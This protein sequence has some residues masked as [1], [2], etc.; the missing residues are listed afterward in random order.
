MWGSRTI[1][2]VDEVTEES[3]WGR[4]EVSVREQYVLQVFYHSCE[5]VSYCKLFWFAGEE[6]ERRNREGEKRKGGR[7]GWKGRMLRIVGCKGM[8]RVVRGRGERG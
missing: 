8:K 4:K 3:V 5:S 2:A 7:E 1:V 6:G